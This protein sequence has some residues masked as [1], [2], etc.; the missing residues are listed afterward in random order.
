MD[1]VHQLVSEWHQRAVWHGCQG[2]WIEL[3]EV[4]WPERP[5]GVSCPA[6]RCLLGECRKKLCPHL[7]DASLTKTVCEDVVSDGVCE[8]CTHHLG[9]RLSKHAGSHAHAVLDHVVSETGHHRKLLRLWHVAETHG[10]HRLHTKLTHS[11]HL[12]ASLGLVHQLLHHCCGVVGH[13]ESC[14]CALCSR[15][16]TCLDAHPHTRHAIKI[17]LGALLVGIGLGQSWLDGG[18]LLGA[19]DR[20]LMM[21]VLSSRDASDF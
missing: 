16:H 5:E 9:H 19:L 6:R 10:L 7:L 1:G 12:L 13:T 2:T 14:A 8:W 15:N 4:L 3:I 17:L 21:N 20:S 18:C 11:L